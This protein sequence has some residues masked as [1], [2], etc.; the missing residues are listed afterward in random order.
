[1][2]DDDNSIPHDAWLLRRIPPYQVVQDKNAE[3]LRPSSAAFK[4]PALSV[5]C[6]A[7]LHQHG[8]DWRFTLRDH[9]G[10]SLVRFRAASARERGLSVV[11]RPLPDNPAHAEVV[12]KKT[13]AIASQLSRISEWVHL[14]LEI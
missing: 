11:L 6:E 10:F 13:Q 8:Q 9:P 2:P 12:G 5:D 14:D 3:L 7:I 4:D 1:M